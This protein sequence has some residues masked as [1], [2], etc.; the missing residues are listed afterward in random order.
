MLCIPQFLL[1]LQAQLVLVLASLGKQHLTI[2]L[3]FFGISHP[4][5]L[6][7]S[8]LP[9][10]LS[11]LCFQCVG[12]VE[13]L[14]GDTQR[15]NQGQVL[16]AHPSA[17]LTCISVSQ[18]ERNL[19]ILNNF[20]LQMRKLR[21]GEIWRFRRNSHTLMQQSCHTNLDYKCLYPKAPGTHG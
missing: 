21:P 4:P 8:L 16:A 15:R 1:Y 13:A 3:L 20:I 14:I 9:F 7:I 19:E 10:P 17:H 18:Q 5:N 11:F 6:L 12:P 2:T